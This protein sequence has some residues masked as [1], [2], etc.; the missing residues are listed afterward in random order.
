MT[1]P[2]HPWRNFDRT[3]PSA[4]ARC[5]GCSAKLGVRRRR[6]SLTDEGV[7]T[8]VE[9]EAGLT[10]REIAGEQDLARTTV[11]DVLTRAGVKMRPAARRRQ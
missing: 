1:E 6:K 8:L 5:S 9:D 3:T 4:E 10:I 7:A 2:A 11:Q